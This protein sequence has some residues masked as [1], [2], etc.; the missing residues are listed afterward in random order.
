MRFFFPRTCHK[1]RQSHTALFYN[2]SNNV[3]QYSDLARMERRQYC[4]LLSYYIFHLTGMNKI[5]QEI[6]F[7]YY[8]Q[9][10]KMPNKFYRCI[11]LL[12]GHY[13]CVILYNVHY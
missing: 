13:I 8:D 7:R 1:P 9:D 3:R 4:S 11:K 6:I 5:N 12:L 10:H 2:P